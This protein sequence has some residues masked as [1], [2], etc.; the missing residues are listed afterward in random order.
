LAG[1]GA[2]PILVRSRGEVGR[3]RRLELDKDVGSRFGAQMRMV[4]HHT[5]L[6]HDGDFRSAGNGDGGAEE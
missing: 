6:V 3:G 1:G 5:W 2:W 4:A